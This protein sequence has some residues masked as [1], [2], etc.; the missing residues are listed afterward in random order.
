[1]RA[2]VV[3]MTATAVLALSTT[4][5]LAT[6][7]VTQGVLPTEICGVRSGGGPLGPVTTAVGPLTAAAAPL[8]SALEPVTTAL[9][10]VLTALCGP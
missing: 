3:A 2:F 8:T 10:P 5:A 9:A 1:M 7:L 4:A 6:P